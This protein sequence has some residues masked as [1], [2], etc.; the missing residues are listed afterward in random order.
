[1]DFN[2]PQSFHS[3][4]IP[5]VGG[6]ASIISLIIFFAAFNLFFKA[7]LG[8]YIYF[9]LCLFF[10]LGF[11]EDIKIELNPSLRLLLMALI[12]LLGFIFFE[13]RITKTG[14]LFFK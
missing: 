5:R 7:E 9:F 3:S 6:L 11:L 14:F 10:L 1:M 13:I 12:L 4:P 8:G 2:K